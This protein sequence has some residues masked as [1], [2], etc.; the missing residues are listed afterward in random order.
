M[1]PLNCYA[2]MRCCV[3]NKY[4]AHPPFGEPLAALKIFASQNRL[5]IRNPESD[6]VHPKCL[7]KLKTLMNWKRKES[8]CIF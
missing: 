5:T 2:G 8:K 4:G 1:M 3:C 6:A 7:K